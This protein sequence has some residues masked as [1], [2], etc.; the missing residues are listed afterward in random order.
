MADAAQP[1]TKASH[2]FSA[3]G[4]LVHLAARWR[5]D[6]PKCL[7]ALGVYRESDGIRLTL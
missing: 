4:T 6:S 7:I 2:L 3:P 5:V 1:S